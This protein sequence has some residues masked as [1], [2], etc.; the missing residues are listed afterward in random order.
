MS[1]SERLRSVVRTIV[2]IEVLFNEWKLPLACP[3]DLDEMNILLVIFLRCDGK[4]MAH[5]GFT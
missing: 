3:Y 2:I 4:D 1:H 5:I